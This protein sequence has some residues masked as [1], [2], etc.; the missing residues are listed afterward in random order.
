[1]PKR[2]RD[3]TALTPAT[4][5]YVA[6]DRPGGATGRATIATDPIPNTLVARNAQGT[7][8]EGTVYDVIKTLNLRGVYVWDPALSFKWVP[9]V[10]WTG[11]VGPYNGLF[12][13]LRIARVHETSLGSRLRVKVSTDQNASVYDQVISLAHDFDVV[14]GNAVLVQP[15]V[16]VFE[17]WAYV[18]Y[19][20]I[21]VDGL[22]G[23]DEGDITITPYGEISPLVQNSPPPPMSGGIYLEWQS[24]L[25]H[26]TFLGPGY[27]V[28]A[29]RNSTSGY[30]RYDNSVQVAW[31]TITVGSGSW[32]YPA[33]F[34]SA[35][36]VV[37]TAEASG[38]P[39]VVTIT[40]VSTTAAGLLRTDLSG[41][42]QSGTVHLW[43]IGLWK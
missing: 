41:N 10:R 40:S 39:R 7:I 37:A 11:F 42:T 5:D 21:Y 27:I 31:A 1:M 43:A 36:R 33:A 29:G 17:L 38:V 14:V 15:A 19:T 23:T 9:L 24:A 22:A 35:P 25:P 8:Q 34:A 4:G 2:I 32:T 18:P 28:A 16:G 26:Q 12:A 20:D 3:L 13:D 30:V 6:I